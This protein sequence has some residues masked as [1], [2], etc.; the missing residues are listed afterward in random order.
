MEA[1]KTERSRSFHGKTMLK[2]LTVRVF[3]MEGA[4]VKSSNF[5]GFFAWISVFFPIK[6]YHMGCITAVNEQ[7]NLLWLPLRSS[8][9]GKL[10]QIHEFME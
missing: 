7:T 9:G 8:A 4:L 6:P 10:A 5:G 1:T 3:K 2:I